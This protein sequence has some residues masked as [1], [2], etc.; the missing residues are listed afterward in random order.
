MRR[1][2]AFLFAV[3]QF[4]CG[5][6]PGR[7]FAE[8]LTPEDLFA[9]FQLNRSQFPSLHVQ[10]ERTNQW[11]DGWRAY[12]A[13]TAD[14]SERLSE[15]PDLDPAQRSS[16]RQSA[17]LLRQAA[18]TDKPQFFFLDYWTDGA[19][20][21]ARS[22]ILAPEDVRSS[23]DFPT[24]PVSAENL[25]EIYPET[26]ICSFD[27]KASPR[28]RVWN[29]IR[30]NGDRSGRVTDDS[31]HAVTPGFQFP[32]LGIQ[33]PQWAPTS[34]WN[35]IDQYFQDHSSGATLVGQERVDDRDL[36]HLRTITFTDAPQG[37]ARSPGRFE[38]GSIVDAWIDPSQGFLPVR[39]EWNSGIYRDRQPIVVNRTPHKRVDV[40][41]VRAI[42]GAGFYPWSG[43]ARDFVD[44]PTFKPSS[45]TI[46]D[47]V[48]GATP[49]EPPK[50]VH[51]MMGWT[52]TALEPRA[53]ITDLMKRL[54][55][56][57]ST[58]YFD[59]RRQRV[60]IQGLS[61]SEVDRMLA[62]QASGPPVSGQTASPRSMGWLILL[63]GIL[64]ALV[65]TAAIV[66]ARKKQ[67]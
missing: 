55:F 64:I 8:S 38:I 13:K 42:E 39:I 54:E 48:K 32:P 14:Q 58:N 33:D 47:L 53:E 45:L 17:Q 43:L 27:P 3:L 40:L 46:D 12:A 1:S 15:S 30:G 65:V 5:L 26:M 29:G 44:D 2:T 24:A 63:N 9:G 37:F 50:L 49:E 60:M 21:H 28:L 57:R 20:F 62:E 66:R 41:E 25:V 16:L 31:I 59:D 56:P 6:V 36:Y 52:V 11:K 7:G 22:P 35:P 19:A 18:T 61:E 34:L 4:S 51:T 10:M 23:W 67:S